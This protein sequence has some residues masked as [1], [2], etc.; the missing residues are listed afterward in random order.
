[1]GSIQDGARPMRC[2]SRFARSCS[3]TN[4]RS[5]AISTSVIFG[6]QIAR[7]RAGVPHRTL[8]RRRA[9]LCLQRGRARRD[10]R[11]PSRLEQ[12][13]PKAQ[14]RRL[15]RLCHRPLRISQV[16]AL[17]AL[18]DLAPGRRAGPRGGRRQPGFR[19][20][21]SRSDLCRRCLKLTGLGARCKIGSMYAIIETDGKQLRV[22]E[23]ATIRCDAVDREAGSQIAF[24]RVVLASAGSSQVI[25]GRPLVEGARSS[26]SK[27][28][29]LGC[30]RKKR[31]M[32]ASRPQL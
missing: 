24:E 20:R 8:A 1:M 10:G 31:G 23:G 15:P 19:P 6:S 7:D 28:F 32:G 5:F 13:P 11:P 26:V 30:K 27:I 21:R 29:Y 3:R 14:R 18:P 16:R 4:A 2:F 17:G 12:A 22:S 25:V 9:R